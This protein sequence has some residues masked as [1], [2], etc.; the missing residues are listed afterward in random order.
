MATSMDKLR[1]WLSTFELREGDMTKDFDRFEKLEKIMWKRSADFPDDIQTLYREKNRF[2]YQY[3]PNFYPDEPKI[4]YKIFPALSPLDLGYGSRVDVERWVHCEVLDIFNR[5]TATERRVHNL[6]KDIFERVAFKRKWELGTLLAKKIKRDFGSAY[7]YKGNT[8][9]KAMY[10]IIADHYESGNRFSGEYYS[11]KT[12][13][14]IR[15]WNGGLRVLN[16][17]CDELT[18]MRMI[19]GEIEIFQT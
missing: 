4:V 17:P 1:N 8:S 12:Y 15:S 14:H 18:T 5:I 3:K 2:V 10:L 19:A 16:Q 13:L 6:V 7:L 11:Y 9:S